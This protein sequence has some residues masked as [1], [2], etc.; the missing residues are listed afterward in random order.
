MGSDDTSLA[1]VAR[2]RH[3]S[4]VLRIAI[5]ALAALLLQAVGR[6]NWAFP[7]LFG[8]VAV[9]V[10]LIG[11]GGRLHRDQPHARIVFYALCWTSYLLLCA[12]CWHLWTHLGPIGVAASTMLMCGLLMHLIVYTMRQR[13]LFWLCASPLI[14]QLVLIPPLAMGPS[15]LGLGLS[16]S[17]CALLVVGY[18]AVLWRSFQ[19]TLAS[20]DVERRIALEKQAEADLANAAKSQFLAAM[21]HEIRTPLNGVLGMVQALAATPLQDSQ[22]EMVETIDQSGQALMTILD[23]VLD[24]AKLE[25]GRLVLDPAPFQPDQLLARAAALFSGAACAKGLSL[26][27][28][29]D[30]RCGCVLVGDDTRIRQIVLNLLSNA[31]KFTSAGGIV[32]GA[33]LED[34]AGS[35]VLTITVRDSGPGMSSE[36]Q[37]RLFQ[38]FAQGDASTTRQFGG[39]GLG[40]AIARDLA[41]LMGGSL[42]VESELGR[43]S[44]FS[45]DL[46]LP[47]DVDQDLTAAAGPTLV[48]A[49]TPIGPASIRILAAEDN[50]TNQLVLRTLMDQIGFDLTIVSNG[51]E[52]V[53][54]W[55]LGRFDVILMDMHMPLMD[56]LQATRAIRAHEAQ[57]GLPRTPVVALTA[58]AMADQVGQCSRAGMDAHVAK[59]IHLATLLDV[60]QSVL[61]PNEDDEEVR[62][63][64]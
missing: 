44:A 60:L 49:L 62:A 2:G 22:R 8:Y 30:P 39:T 43:G 34:A 33:S 25:A 56:G 64:S 32:L 24:V 48:V 14:T 58:N 36:V 5:I 38:Q 40:L 37:S 35:A 57:A 7:W 45:L 23:A 13:L 12:P 16:G 46:Q 1:A 10:A 47:F 42:S 3:R 31:V 63:A 17:I 59:P 21:S 4:T 11:V 55:R 18:M 9:Q 53:E 6:W 19:K 28:E 51:A 41:E 52:A 29:V 54:S 20:M 26:A 61:Q 15:R 50:P 27:L